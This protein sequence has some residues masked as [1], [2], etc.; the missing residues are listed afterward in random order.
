V[1]VVASV[2]GAHFEL[3][4]LSKIG[5]KRV[6][7]GGSLSRVAL[8]ACIRAA[9]EMRDHGTFTFVEEPITSREIAAMLALSTQ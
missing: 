9:M 5:V 1:N 7:V 6:S 3:A 2:Q 4:A 8:A